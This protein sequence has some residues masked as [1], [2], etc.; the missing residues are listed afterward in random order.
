M[1][2]KA[3]NNNLLRH[4][5]VLQKRNKA[6]VERAIKHI[7]KL[8]G[9]VTMS[10]VSKVTYE[11]A[12]I[13]TQEKGITLAG[14]SKNPTYRTLVE[15]ARATSDFTQDKGNTNRLSDGDIRLLLHAKRVENNELKNINKILTQQ[16]RETP[17]VLETSEPIS[18][19]LIKEYHNMKTTVRAITNR[20]CEAELAYI[21]A[22]TRTLRLE[23]YNDILI[24]SEVLEIFYLKELDDIQSK[25][26]GYPPD[27]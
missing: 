3:K 1:K 19:T 10:M 16:L 18:D 24:H 23:L 25:V 26:R 7:M 6:L 22:D 2:N 27:N 14:I 21:D 15:Q 4:K 12:D 9:K 8:S 20:L 11:I 5:E 17:N 13:Q